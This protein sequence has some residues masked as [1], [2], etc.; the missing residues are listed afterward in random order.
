MRRTDS[1]KKTLMLGKIEGR[2][3]RG[4]QRV[5]RFNG[6]TD[7]MDM[8]LSRL[9]ELEMNREALHAAVHGVTKS[10]TQLSDW[11]EL[12]LEI[13]PW[14]LIFPSNTVL[15]TTIC[16]ISEDFFLK[17]Y[18]SSR[19]WLWTGKPGLLQSMGLQRVRHDWVTE[20]NWLMASNKDIN[21]FCFGICDM[22]NVMVQIC[23]FVPSSKVHGQSQASSFPAAKSGVPFKSP[24]QLPTVVLDL[25]KTLI[26]QWLTS[27]KQ[28]KR[29]RL[30]L[31]SD[32]FTLT[33]TSSSSS[34]IV[35]ITNPNFRLPTA[36]A[37]NFSLWCNIT[38]HLG[39][40][41]SFWLKTLQQSFKRYNLYINHPHLSPAPPLS[42]A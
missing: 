5:R 11:T 38:L 27:T 30:N 4:Q 17:E 15:A 40:K 24:Y 12:R 14:S 37:V 10:H 33:L 39:K 20:L 32:K 16:I 31:K 8:S 42:L 26:E 35:F 28:L 6:I 3:R 36:L 21:S 19:S 22:L 41:N 34:L 18:K 2:R 9:Q 23:S 29:L 7:S 1:L 13:L 25:L